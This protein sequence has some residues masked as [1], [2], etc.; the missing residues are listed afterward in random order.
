MALR[1]ILVVLSSLLIGAH[2]LRH[3]NVV[4]VLLCLVAP[5]LL[6]LK[7]RWVLIVL[8]CFLYG[9]ALLWLLYTRVLVHQRMLEHRP[10]RGV[11]LIL[12]SVALV[13]VLSG[14]LLNSRSMKDRYPNKTAA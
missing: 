5:F 8:Q 14:L 10:F 11:I 1:T 2:F 6:L 7:K 3:G 12:G 9:A 4:A 13:T